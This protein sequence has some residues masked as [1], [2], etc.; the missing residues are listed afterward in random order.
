MRGPT[1]QHSSEPTDEHV[2]LLDVEERVERVTLARGD[3]TAG[4]PLPWFVFRK[5]GLALT[6]FAALVLLSY[7]IPLPWAQ[8]WRADEDYVPFWNLLGRGALAGG[9]AED[10][11]LAE[12]EAAA[13]LDELAAHVDERALAPAP[14]REALL[15]PPPDGLRLPAYVEHA[16]DP[17]PEDLVVS[18]EQ[19]E[20][21]AP[22]FAALSLTD[23][24][25]AGAI[26]RVAHWGDSV[27]GNDGITSAIRQ[28]MQARF[29][30]AGHG[31]HALEKYDASYRHRGVR[32]EQLG[33][34]RWS[35]CMI[36]NLC[37]EDGR[38]GYGGATV[39]SS[40]GSH[41]RFATA[42]KGEFGRKAA[43]FEVWYAARPGGGRLRVEIDGEVHM[44]DT[45]LD[46]SAAEQL[47]EAALVDRWARF[48]VPDGAHVFEVRAGGGGQVRAY[49]V[50]LERDAAGVVWDG[51][52]LIGSF[53]KRLLAQD[54]EHLAAQLGHRGINLM[55]FSF[56]G[57]DMTR[58]R[59]D[60]RTTMDPYVADFGVVIDRFRAAR[61]EAACLIVGPVDHGERV[62]GR[63]RSRKI[64]A[65]LT[66]AQRE[67]A[68]E[69]G[70]AFFDTL[71]AMGGV[72]SV[73]R[74]H[75]RHLMSVD[76]AHPS[77]R[78]HQVIGA[79]IHAALMEGYVE[80][81]RGRVGEVIDVGG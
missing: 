51:M 53:T 28:R 49:G 81:R 26:T 74:W 70:C 47:G 24:G 27:I 71:A 29:G 75:G 6:T 17:R 61:P 79:M 52:A 58:E 73:A 13:R 50:V 36:R 69:H 16:R 34:V 22:L 62:D 78:G 14:V 4:E 56:G 80:F 18:L 68:R 20:A 31:F 43:V 37:R 35:Q 72:G 60:L 30:D 77:A 32:F 25:Y 23:L 5:L 55:V 40:G 46:P 66:E 3:L 64:S 65:R 42:Q 48:E 33:R 76:L 54:P 67:V 10:G 44:I 45:A 7:L 57:N 38:Y 11:A 39:W 63:V 41:S 9:G 21:L 15:A 8:P 1:T 19:P 59:S 2:G 12:A